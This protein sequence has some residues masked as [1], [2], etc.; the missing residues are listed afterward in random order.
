MYSTK[1]KSGKPK[2]LKDPEAPKKPLSSFIHFCM[3][4]RANVQK[5]LLYTNRLLN[6]NTVSAE[7]TKELGKRW[8][9]LDSETRKVYEEAGLKDRKRYEMEKKMYNPSKEFLKKKA[10]FEG[11]PK[12]SSI[13]SPIL[14]ATE[15]VDDHLED[16]FNFLHINWKKVQQANPGYT[17][18]QTQIEVLRL[19]QDQK[20]DES[21]SITKVLKKDKFKNNGV[22]KAFKNPLVPKRPLSAFFLYVR[23]KRA[24]VCEASPN[25]SSKEVAMELG[26]VWSGLG[27]DDKAPYIMEASKHWEIFKED[28][29]SYFK[30]KTQSAVVVEMNESAN[31]QSFQASALEMDSE[32]IEVDVK[33][34][35]DSS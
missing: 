32:E 10:E 11:A 6:C 2:S 23:D 28:M 14:K 22:R 35:E 17:I 30:S 29:K 26:K 4:E 15:T 19:W 27:E 9:T 1:G 8:A 12:F 16:Y 25:L 18:N 7:V 21:V 5:E 33:F 34:E 3:M 31:I 24:E 20:H 13:K